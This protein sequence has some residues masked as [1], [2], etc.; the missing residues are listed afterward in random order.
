[1]KNFNMSFHLLGDMKG[2]LNTSAS[3]TNERHFD[4]YYLSI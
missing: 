4:D 3:D 2:Y 1:M